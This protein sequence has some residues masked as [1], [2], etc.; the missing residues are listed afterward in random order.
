MD[1]SSVGCCRNWFQLRENVAI[2]FFE[3][4][5]L[6]IDDGF[7]GGEICSMEESSNLYIQVVSY[8]QVTVGVFGGI[9]ARYPMHPEVINTTK[10]SFVE[11]YYNNWSKHE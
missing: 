9:G 4:T 1:G 2:P 11:F 5:V 10:E 3:V 6:V 7:H 8:S